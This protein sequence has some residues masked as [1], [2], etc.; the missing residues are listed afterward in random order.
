MAGGR[1][2]NRHANGANKKNAWLAHLAWRFSV[3]RKSV[4]LRVWRAGAKKASG[5]KKSG[6][7]GVKYGVV[8]LVWFGLRD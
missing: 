5:R 1:R 7:C 2:K 3:E 8:R 6:V 4:W